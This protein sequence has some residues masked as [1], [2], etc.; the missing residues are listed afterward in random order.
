MCA[1]SKFGKALGSFYRPTA[2]AAFASAGAIT[3]GVHQGNKT[4]H[5]EEISKWHTLSKGNAYIRAF[6]TGL[7]GGALIGS[8]VW[9]LFP[10]LVVTLPVYGIYTSIHKMMKK[11]PSEERTL[12]GEEPQ[13]EGG[14]KL[15]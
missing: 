10:L 15:Q 6:E 7:F 14:S 2:F 9:L 5:G 13:R 3:G 12:L 11:E 4:I 8:A 1:A